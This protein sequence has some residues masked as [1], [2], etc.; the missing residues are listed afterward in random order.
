MENNFF[1]IFALAVMPPN[2]IH[3]S[4]CTHVYIMYE[5]EKE[6]MFEK[7][8]IFYFS[9]ACGHLRTALM[10]RTSMKETA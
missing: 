7:I 5:K 8:V 2:F 9:S 10:I 1:S 4:K 3:F 6:N